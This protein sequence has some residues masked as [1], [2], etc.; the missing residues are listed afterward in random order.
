MSQC[1]K[2]GEGLGD[3]LGENLWLKTP[4]KVRKLQ[5]ALYRKAKENRQWRFYSLYGEI[6]RADVL[7]AALDQVIKNDGAAGVDGQ[8]I[9]TLK[10]SAQTREKFLLDLQGELRGKTYRPSPVRRVWS[11][12]DPAKTKLRP[13][14]IP[15]VKDRVVQ[16][17]VALLLMPIWEADFHEH[18]YA[19]R[20]KRRTTQA[21]EAIVEAL[22]SGQNEIV[23][24][25]LSKYFD[26]IPH[27]A[28]MK[29]VAKRVSDGSILGLIKAWLRAP[30]VERD[31][32]TDRTRV[33]PNTKGTPQGGV[34]SPLLANLYLN[35]LDHVVN[36]KDPQKPRMIRYADDLVILCRRG[37]GKGMLEKLGRWTK[38]RG[39]AIN[40]AKTR[41]VH[42]KRENFNFLGFNVS[43]RKSGRDRNYV[44]VEPAASSQAKLRGK[45]QAIL[46]AWTHNQPTKA[47]ITRLNQLTRGWAQA[48]HYG[49]STRVFGRLQQYVA[50]RLRDWLWKKHTRSRPRCSYY[51]NVRLY[52]QYKLWKWPRNA[53]WKLA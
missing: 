35:P 5:L 33:L 15:T 11:W 32:T 36:E 24:A 10:A 34:I 51:S 21:M 45:V 29:L 47:I 52:G 44:H 22:F 27:G 8:D 42:A 23:D 25:D 16:T 31:R 39:L 53:V 38:A 3:G 37:Q 46:N 40:D 12:K 19:Y 7:S 43:W 49:N 14:G 30:I 48:F 50:L 13:L 20:P 26:T 17:A 18:S 28:I 4:P 2:R 41:I 1:V 9:R 6:C